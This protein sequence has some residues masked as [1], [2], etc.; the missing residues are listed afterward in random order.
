MIYKKKILIDLDHLRKKI[1]LLIDHDML[2]LDKMFDNGIKNI[3]KGNYTKH[4]KETILVDIN[5]LKQKMI[6]LIDNYQLLDDVVKDINKG[7]HLN[8]L[9]ETKE[10]LLKMKKYK[11]E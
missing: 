3:E 10:I 9:E 5:K 7:K 8:S 6:L 1:V 4:V 11:F 2:L